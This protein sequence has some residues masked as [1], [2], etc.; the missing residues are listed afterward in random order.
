MSHSLETDFD[1]VVS[2]INQYCEG[3]YL[4]DAKML[5]NIFHQDAWL[6]L[7]G[8]RRSLS[9]WLEDVRQRQTPKDL[10][11]AYDFKILSV[12]LVQDQA[13]VKLECPLFDFHYI[14]FLGLLKEEGQW[15]IVNKMYTDIA[16]NLKVN[17]SLSKSNESVHGSGS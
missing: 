9:T 3:L 14:D 16:S 4:G 8:K 17:E 12:D 2:I 1:H 6:K 7:P 13:M 11:Q 15:R 5:E 10:G